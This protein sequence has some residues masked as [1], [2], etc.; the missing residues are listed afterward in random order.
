MQVKNK[1]PGTYM[2]ENINHKKLATYTC[3]KNAH[4]TV[5]HF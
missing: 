1:T 5:K 3:E 4:T 2:K